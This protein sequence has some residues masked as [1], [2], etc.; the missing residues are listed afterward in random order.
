MTEVRTKE[1]I[2]IMREGG[3]LLATGLK[4]AVDAVQAGMTLR[5][6]N[7]IADKTLRAGGGKPSFLGY[8]SRA[9]DTP[10]PSAVCISV[11]D[12]IVH[13]SGNRNRELEDGDIVSLDIGV[14][15]KGMC[16][17]MAVT[18]P[19][20]KV[21]D[22]ATKLMEVTKESMLRAIGAVHGGVAVSEIGRACE[23]YVKPHGYGIVRDLV[24]HGV[25]KKVHEEPHIPNFDP[26]YDKVHLKTGMT[27]AVEPMLTAGDPTIKFAEDGWAVL[28]ADGLLSA[29]FEVTLLVTDDG[30]ELMTPLVV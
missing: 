30:Y 25:G 3:A 7:A 19:V 12:E 14:W 16:T 27:I 4:A 20:G 21:S 1:E 13:A 23:T 18:V 9:S 5:E 28:T 8:Q 29:H 6:L 22:E 15:H 17:D 26:R 24:G 2:E 11:N 10:F